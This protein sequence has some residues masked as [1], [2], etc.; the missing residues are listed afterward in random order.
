MA[1]RRERLADILER[2]L[3]AALQEWEMQR[4]VYPQE[5]WRVNHERAVRARVTYLL[6]DILSHFRQ[7]ASEQEQEEG[8]GAGDGERSG[9]V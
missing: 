2:H 7:Y 9:G 4:R 3:R 1:V 5:L 8:S 6:E